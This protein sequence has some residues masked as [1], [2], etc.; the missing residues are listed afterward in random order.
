MTFSFSTFYNLCS[1]EARYEL[2]LDLIYEKFKPAHCLIG[3]FI[4]ADTRVKTVAY[5]VD[6]N[7]SNDIIYD[8]EG[9]PCND[10]K[11]SQ[12]VCSISCNLQQMYAEDEI[13]KIFNIDGYLGVTLRALDH[14]PI[15]IMVCLFD[16][17]VT[18]S[19]EDKH[20]FRELSLLVGAE[21]NH[22]LEIAAQQILVKQLAKGER[23]AKLSSWS[24]N[25]S[26]DKHIFSHEMRRLLQHREETLTL[27][28][29]TNCLTEADQKRLRV[30]IQKLRTG[31]L[32]YIDVNV[33]HKKRTN[34]RGLYRIIGRVEQCDEQRDERVF[35]ATVQ[36]VSYIYSLNKQ[37]ELTNV[38]FEHATEAIM[39]TDGENKII[40]VNRAFE[41][42]TGY[43]GHELMGRDPSVLSSG[44]HGD[45]FYHQM[46][47]S[48]MSAGC[49]KGEI[50]NR[51]KNGQIFPE[52]LTLS[53]V[54]DEQGEIVNYVAIFRDITE[55]KRN[56]AQLMFYANHEPLTALLNRR[57]FI[58]IVEEKISASRSLHT[59]CSLLF[60]G[61]D[62]FK[63]VNDIYGPEIGDKVLVSVAKRL[64]NGIRENDTI[65][66]YGGDEFAILLD[67]TDVKSALQVAK[68]LSDKIKQP[69]VFNDLTVELS[70]STGIA[71]LENRGRITA[72]KFI[73]NAAHALE[74][75][76]KTHRGHVALH[77]A[78]IQNAYLN[79]IKLKDK[80][81]A[82]LKA[83]L[84][85]VY[86][87]PIVDVQRGKIV[88][89]EALV[90]WFDDEQGMVSPGTFIPIAEEFGLIHLI[91]QFV[92]EQACQDLKAIHSQGYDEV[93]ISI[94]RSVNEFKTSNDQFK[95]VTEAIE[96]AQVPYDKVTLEVTESM[97]TNRYTW[98][99]LS[100]L[101]AQGVKIALD[102]FCTGYSS[103]SHLVENQVDYLK[104]DKS[105]VDSLMADRN[106]KVMISCLLNLAQELGIKVIAEGV[107]SQSQLVMLEQLGCNHIQGFYY[108][109]AQPLSACLRLLQEFNSGQ[110]F[111]DELIYISKS[112]QQH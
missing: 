36:D 37:L 12:G 13:L 61:L 62:H 35:S 99:L 65:S 40:M 14:K 7:R 27:D 72:A 50:F 86:Y 2:A 42:L 52:E 63:E 24:W 43:T 11:T 67:N 79:K 22:N 34:L 29:F 103:L 98:E 108:S 84:L 88:K 64:R 48:L 91:G 71:Q 106:K 26:R 38:V 17:K 97:A 28:D 73:R 89:F 105:F 6:G 10:A 44:Q 75:A 31:H 57:C 92:L 5:S 54:K 110:V 83:N 66:R 59:P 107:E 4:D 109:P 70:A 101:R 25:I 45:D 51:R 87:Q 39:I 81:K 55:W 3:K 104:I 1:S 19:D 20:W 78:A 30:I 47:N 76:K 23:I 16:E 46:W 9:T 18:V 21:L 56:E 90:R 15:G 96:K 60:I 85:T 8:L 100:K 53:L 80:L 93:S 58:D 82:A 77:N 102:D 33:A 49:W 112:S 111:N 95:L 32:D 69:Y 68:K 41:R 94:N 74:S